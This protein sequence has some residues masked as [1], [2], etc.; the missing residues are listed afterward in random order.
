MTGGRWEARRSE[1]KRRRPDRRPLALPAPPRAKTKRLCAAVFFSFFRDEFSLC[2][3]KLRYD[4]VSAARSDAESTLAGSKAGSHRQIKNRPKAGQAAAAHH[5]S[6][7]KKDSPLSP[8]S[9]LNPYRHA[10]ARLQAPGGRHVPHRGGGEE[11][12]GGVRWTDGGRAGGDG[13]SDVVDGC[14]RQKTP[15]DEE[16]KHKLREPSPVPFQLLLFP[17]G[18]PERRY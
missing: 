1:G 15:I 5:Q 6:K 3:Y 7:T 13:K 12:K 11:G 8:P 17:I 2:F 14:D 4:L 16:K 18:P 10:D 9:N